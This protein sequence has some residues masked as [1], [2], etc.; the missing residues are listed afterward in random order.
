MSPKIRERYAVL[1]M[2][3]DGRQGSFDPGSTPDLGIPSEWVSCNNPRACVLRYAVEEGENLP[4]AKTVKSV[5]AAW[6][7]S[8]GL[9]KTRVTVLARLDENGIGHLRQAWDTKQRLIGSNVTLAY[10]VVLPKRARIQSAGIDLTQRLCR[11]AEKALPWMYQRLGALHREDILEA[12]PGWPKPAWKH[13]DLGSE[14]QWAPS[15]VGRCLLESV[16]RSIV[17]QGARRQAFTALAAVGQKENF[18]EQGRLYP[19]VL[20]ARTLWEMTHEGEDAPKAGLLLGVAGQMH[21]DYLRRAAGKWNGLTWAE[22][23]VLSGEPAPPPL[24]GSYT[25]LQKAPRMSRFLMTYAA[26]DGARHGRAARYAISDDGASLDVELLLPDKADPG[27]DDWSWCSFTPAKAGGCGHRVGSR[28]KA[29]GPRFTSASGRAM[30][31]G[32]ESRCFAQRHVP[33]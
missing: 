2:P 6:A 21:A 9:K 8:R 4:Q 27:P 28:G 5:L 15:R 11:P 20:E 19:L 31:A 33:G 1:L 12:A 7:K 14:P 22:W 18:L 17:S 25:E 29:A 30:G 32:P 26:D 13:G 24:A 3:R 16:G 23:A 10:P